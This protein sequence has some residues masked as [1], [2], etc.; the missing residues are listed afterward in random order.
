MYD[1]YVTQLCKYQR[2]HVR[3]YPTSVCGPLAAAARLPDYRDAV[4]LHTYASTR[5]VCML[6]HCPL[7]CLCAADCTV[8]AA[9]SSG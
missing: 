3:I 7:Y 5:L 6:S 8:W 9:Q 1:V 4:F 2:H